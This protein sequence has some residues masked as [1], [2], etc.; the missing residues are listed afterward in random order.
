[1]EETMAHGGDSQPSLAFFRL[2]RHE[3]LK[4]TNIVMSA[5]MAA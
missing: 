3:N 5:I 2:F 1:M 4:M